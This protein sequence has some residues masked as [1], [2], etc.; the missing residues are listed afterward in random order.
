MMSFRG[1][2]RLMLRVVSAY[3]PR[4]I[5]DLFTIYQQLL[6]HY[7]EEDTKCTDTEPLTNYD[8]DLTTL[9]TSWMD[10]GDQ[11]IVMIDSSLD[12]ANNNKGT[13]RHKLEEIG[14]HELLLNQH[15]NLKPPATRF[16]G[17]LT[18]DGILA[19]LLLKLVK[20]Y[21]HNSWVSLIIG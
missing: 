2:N 5:D 10:D 21:T 6:H 12:L 15:S 18:I 19:H 13:F 17:R 7:N 4:S 3:R 9:I 14:M 20:E 16:P 8:N 11:V 1:K